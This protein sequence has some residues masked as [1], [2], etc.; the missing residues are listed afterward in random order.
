[1]T[2]F[3]NFD[4]NTLKALR[5]E[6]QEVMNKYA[7][8]ANLSIEVGSMRFSDAEVEIKV[9]A[10]VVGAVT[11]TDKMLESAAKNLGISNFKNSIGDQLVA[12]KPSSYKYPFVYVSAADGKR[13]KCSGIMAK[14]K[15]A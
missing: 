1:M 6:M 13:Y 4:K 8:A 14:M 7:A 5:A 11:M 10:K 3:A 9:K 2:K 15:F 12:Y